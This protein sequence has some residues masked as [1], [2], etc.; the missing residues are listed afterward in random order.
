M[1]AQ[2]QFEVIGGGQVFDHV[3]GQGAEIDV[4]A[5]A[6]PGGRYRFLAVAVGHDQGHPLTDDRRVVTELH[7]LEQMVGTQALMT[8]AQVLHILLAPDKTLVGRG[9]DEF[10]GRWHFIALDEIGPELQRG[11]EGGVDGQCALDLYL[12]LGI[13]RGVV[14]LAVAGVTGAGIVPAVCTFM[15][16]VIKTFNHGDLQGRVQVFEHHP[17]GGAHDAAPN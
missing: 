1:V 17:Q 6:N 7:I 16:D 4:G 13:L 11:L 3:A 2:Q 5:I 8:L 14:Q 15:G 12:P 10:P 9:I